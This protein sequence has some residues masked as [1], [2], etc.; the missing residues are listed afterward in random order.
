MD[1]ERRP[2]LWSDVR[3]L[4]ALIRDSAYAWSE[5]RASRKGAA[6]AYYMAF[7]LA[8][9][10]IIATAVAGL[11]FGEA[12]ARGQIFTQA[13]SLL[14]ADGARVVQSMIAN[15]GRPGRGTWPAILGI[16]TI[17]VGATSALAELKDGLDQIWNTQTGRTFRFGRYLLDFARTRLLAIGVI[18]S[19]GLLLIVSLVL[20]ALL[21]GLANEI[22]VSR[23]TDVLL[24]LFNFLLSFGLVTA[25]FATVYKVLPS[26]QLAWRDV[27]VG[28]AVT[29]VLF[30]IGK[31]VIGVYL[32]S[33]ASTSMYGAA[34]SLLVVL[35][36]VYYSA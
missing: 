19:L 33:R 2:P 34:G 27:I 12:A 31:H 20:S 1:E 15:A 36:W 16:V 28:A 13:K 5:D 8:P 29:A 18:L 11:F 7:S 10:L 23:T 35:V 9:M 3:A 30:N 24:Q 21:A 32:G 17:V 26:V 14:G 4:W 6:L 25:L 22:G